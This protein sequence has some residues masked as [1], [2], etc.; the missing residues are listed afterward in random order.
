T[1]IS[2]FI[3]STEDAQCA[4]GGSSLDDDIISKINGLN[5][6]CLHAANW[7]SA[8]TSD[9]FGLEEEDWQSV[10]DGNKNIF[11]AYYEYRTQPDIFSPEV[12]T[13]FG[14]LEGIAGLYN[15]RYNLL[16]LDMNASNSVW[17]RQDDMFTESG[18]K[19]IKFRTSVEY[20]LGVDSTAANDD[21]AFSTAYSWDFFDNEPSF[22]Y[23][24]AFASLYEYSDSDIADV[25]KNK[26]LLD[27]ITS[28]V[29][30]EKV[31][32]NGELQSVVTSYVDSQEIV[33]DQNP[34]QSISGQY[35]KGDNISHDE[36]VKYFED[37]VTKFKEE[38]FYDVSDTD[39]NDMLDQISATIQTPEDTAKI[40]RKLDDLRSLFPS[41]SSATSVGKLYARFRKRV[42]T[43]NIAVERG[44]PLKNILH[45]N[46]KFLDL[47]EPDI[48]DLADSTFDED[49][50]S[51]SDEYIYPDQSFISRNAIYSSTEDNE[52]E[53]EDLSLSLAV[54][55]GLSDDL[56]DLLDNLFSSYDTDALVRNR[57]FFF[58]DYEKAFRTVALINRFFS[59]T[60]LSEF[61]INI[62]P[63][64]SFRF[65]A[66]SITRTENDGD[67]VIS[68]DFDEDVEYPLS[69]TTTFSNQTNS[70]L[71][72]YGLPAPGYY[73][74]ASPAYED[75]LLISQE[76]DYLTIRNFVPRQ[77]D[78]ISSGIP[79]YRLAC[80]SFQDFYDDDIAYYSDSTGYTVDITIEDRTI[81]VASALMDHF[82]SARDKLDEFMEVVTSDFSYNPATGDY[83]E[84]FNKGITNYYSGNLQEAPWIMAPVIY[85]IHQDLV[86]DL[87]DG[88]TEK[89]L[90]AAQTII[91]SIAPYSG[92][93]EALYS[94]NEAFHNFHTDI[95]HKIT[96]TIGRAVNALVGTTQSKAF[97]ST[98]S[99][100]SAGSHGDSGDIYGVLYVSFAG[101]VGVGHVG[102][103]EEVSEEG[104]LG[105][106]SEVMPGWADEVARI[107]GL[108]DDED[109]RKTMLDSVIGAMY[110]YPDTCDNDYGE[111]TDDYDREDV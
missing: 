40:I 18:Q 28:D 59:V 92:N 64:N 33:Y 32:S 65:S 38:D 89:I 109:L 19:I 104:S 34:I 3:T 106:C 26:I 85:C 14:L 62:T 31:F 57:G 4:E 107:E 68:C 63:Y 54:Q 86:Y 5:V 90:E 35:Y 72:V 100:S 8:T 78:S 6:Y 96:G 24:F 46:S 56:T 83:N 97:Q 103:G 22:W 53:V 29:T 2:I 1:Y 110:S 95:Y 91:D 39:L 30:Y 76:T 37:F 52:Q 27:K 23:T 93:Y 7:A 16:T 74:D 47:R 81:E 69:K 44:T 12:E 45:R 13:Y 98:I 43:A 17:T 88:D 42:V 41:K 102:E 50:R 66:A 108:T 61:G 82:G 75:V 49:W 80:F 25:V 48:T 84:F 11:S 71:D 36:I 99:Y 87:Y 70:G 9:M 10:T 79:D 105:K 101:D 111:S 55:E 67:I 21:G 73:S 77:T 20:K 94:F 60:K 51:K 58:F 15:T